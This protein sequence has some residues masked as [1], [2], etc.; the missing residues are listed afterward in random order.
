MRKPY[1]TRYLQDISVYAHGQNRALIR[2]V[3]SH[4]MLWERYGPVKVYMATR[5]RSDPIVRADSHLEC[6][7][8][9]NFSLPRV[10]PHCLAALAGFVVARDCFDPSM[11]ARM[12]FP[13]RRRSIPAKKKKQQQHNESSHNAS[14]IHPPAMIECK[15]MSVPYDRFIV[16]RQTSSSSLT[17]KQTR[18]RR[19]N[20][21]STRT[22]EASTI[23]TSCQSLETAPRMSSS[24][25]SDAEDVSSSSDRSVPVISFHQVPSFE[26]GSNAGWDGPMMIGEEEHATIRDFIQE[27]LEQAHDVVAQDQ[28]YQKGLELYRH[29]ARLVDGVEQTAAAPLL[30]AQEWMHICYTC[31]RY[32]MAVGDYE[33]A[34]H[35]ALREMQY[36]SSSSGE[37]RTLIL[38]GDIGAATYIA[39]A[40]RYHDLARICQYGLGDTPQALLYYQRA[41]EWEQKCLLGC[42][43]SGDFAA[44]LI[45]GDEIRRQIQETKKCIGRIQFALG[46]IDAAMG[47]L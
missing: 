8:L 36:S 25:V 5:Y 1:V 2:E 18:R 9:E 10:F 43:G 41:L 47:M 22:K 32:A 12:A 38:P 21:F 14:S 35:F 34:Y 42:C 40:E 24:S 6:L 4:D 45:R 33:T 27:S 30:S 13:R 17:E 46:D 11:H 29:I 31:T 37:S 20:P 3:W 15:E 19:W 28:D 16:Q 44:P 39:T 7:S 26:A 23:C